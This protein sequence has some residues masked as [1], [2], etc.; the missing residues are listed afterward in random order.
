[1]HPTRLF[2][3]RAPG[4]AGIR[5]E[6]WSCVALELAHQFVL[7]G[8]EPRADLLQVHV[9]LARLGEEF[10]FFF[11]DV[12]LTYSPSTFTR[13]SNNS[14]LSGELFSIAATSCLI[15]PCSTSASSSRFSPSRIEASRAAG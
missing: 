10:V 14:S 12:M 2:S 5:G 1:M 13:A 4:A 6:P 3:K 11:L 15:E 8:S 9:A 7:A